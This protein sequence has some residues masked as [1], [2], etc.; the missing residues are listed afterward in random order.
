MKEK[1]KVERGQNIKIWGT[2]KI[3]EKANN[4]ENVSVIEVREEWVWSSAETVDHSQ[5][6]SERAM[7]E[8]KFK[9]K[10]K[11]EKRKRT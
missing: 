7:A 5:R 8:P 9:D 6:I 2:E 3:G 4:E 10:T 1:V 11:G